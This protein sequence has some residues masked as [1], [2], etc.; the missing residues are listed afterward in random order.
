MWKRR[1][2]DS[3]EHEDDTPL[4]N[5]QPFGTGLKRKK[6]EFVRA[7][8]PTSDELQPGPAAR[9]GVQVADLYASI[10]ISK[11]KG[12]ITTTESTTRGQNGDLDE[13]NPS[14][15]CAECGLAITTSI[16]EHNASIAHQVN[17]N[18]SHP[19]SHLDRSRMGL[20]ALSAQ[21]WDPDA[22]IGLGLDGEG[23]RFPIKVAL[24]KDN[25][26]VGAKLPEGSALE[27]LK[28]VKQQLSSKEVKLKEVADRAKAE[29]MRGEMYG[30][31]DL[32]RYLR[33]GGKEWE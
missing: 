9:D 29:K 21:G 27:A 7:Q 13:P 23:M 20:R 26:G 18:H 16:R 2:S 32:D 8:E 14:D 31:V 4:H 28:K 10:V 17:L 30:S 5:R 33:K 25:L 24:K 12:P 22:R 19:P 15:V 6:V 3:D 11:P 1:N